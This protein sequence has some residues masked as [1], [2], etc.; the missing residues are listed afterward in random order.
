METQLEIICN[1]LN[2]AK[3]RLFCI[4]RSP[5]MKQSL[6]S[7][8]II[9]IPQIDTSSGA[10]VQILLMWVTVHGPPCQ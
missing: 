3:T 1:I 4:T 7:K 5:M 9:K 2:V 6:N 10:M 8:P